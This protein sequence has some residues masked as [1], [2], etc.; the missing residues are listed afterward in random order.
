MRA[1]IQASY[2]TSVRSPL[3][4]IL[5]AL[6]IDLIRARRLRRARRV[7]AAPPRFGHRYHRRRRRP[8][9]LPAE[10]GATV[11]LDLCGGTIRYRSL[12]SR[13]PADTLVEQLAALILDGEL[14]R[15]PGQ[16]K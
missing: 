4:E 15:K 12:V 2:D 8:R 16:A 7:P 14:P 9:D 6:A 13:S 10:T 5:P 1:I 11:L 3:G